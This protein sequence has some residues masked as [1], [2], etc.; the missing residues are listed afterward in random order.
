MEKYEVLSYINIGYS[1]TFIFY[2]C[3]SPQSNPLEKLHQIFR[4]TAIQK[5]GNL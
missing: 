5:D 4:Q 1:E 3:Y 2:I